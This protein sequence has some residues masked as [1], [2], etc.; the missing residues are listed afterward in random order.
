MAHSR[1]SIRFVGGREER[2]EGRG[3]KGEQGRMRGKMI[4]ENSYTYL[5]IPK[6]KAEKLTIME[7][8][9]L[10]NLTER[11]HTT[12]FNSFVLFIFIKHLHLKF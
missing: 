8:Q 1:L 2:T 4:Q 9:C 10:V 5:F 12:L 3:G 6:Y 7:P 11:L